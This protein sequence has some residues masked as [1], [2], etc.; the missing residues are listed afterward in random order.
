MTFYI[1]QLCGTFFQSGGYTETDFFSA[2]FKGNTGTMIL[3]GPECLETSKAKA[4]KTNNET[5]RRMYEKEW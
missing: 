5:Y 2:T 1:C 4:V 3:I